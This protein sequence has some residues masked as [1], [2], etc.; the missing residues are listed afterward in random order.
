MPTIT[1]RRQPSGA[2]LLLHA[3]D[4]TAP[5]AFRRWALATCPGSHC[6]GSLQAL[7]S[8]YMPTITLRRQPSGAELLLHA[9]DHTAPA[10]FRRWALA[11]CPRSHCAGSLQAL[12]CCYMPTIT[13]RRQPSGAEL[14]LHA[15]D[16]TAP[17]AFRRWAQPVAETQ[18]G[19]NKDPS[20]AGHFWET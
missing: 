19:G 8:C 12:S 16:H 5:A 11:T 9:H 18:P 17:A 7:G 2:G 1:L 6:A 15:Q 14:L 13:L 10:A 20:R 3:Q 4:H